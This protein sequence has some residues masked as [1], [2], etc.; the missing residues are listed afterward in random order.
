[1]QFL[2]LKGDNAYTITYTA[3]I[4]DY[5]HF[6]KTAEGIIKSLEIN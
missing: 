6:V 1:M 5:D 3:K 2:T 4:D